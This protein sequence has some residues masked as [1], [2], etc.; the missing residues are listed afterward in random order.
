MNRDLPPLSKADAYR[1]AEIGF[2]AALMKIEREFD[3]D[4]ASLEC[5]CQQ[6]HRLI[7]GRSPEQINAMEITRGL[8]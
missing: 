2:V 1:E 4:R 3:D 8:V 5:L 7:Q 6:F